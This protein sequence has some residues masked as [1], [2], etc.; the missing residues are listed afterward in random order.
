MKDLLWKIGNTL[1]ADNKFYYG[2][3]GVKYLEACLPEYKCNLPLFFMLTTKKSEKWIDLA[4]IELCFLSYKEIRAAA[5][6]K[7]KNLKCAEHA[8]EFQGLNYQF[9]SFFVFES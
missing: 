9:C 4:T 3:E 8:S 2:M 6:T 5:R 7:K 1:L